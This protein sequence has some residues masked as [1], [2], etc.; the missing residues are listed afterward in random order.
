MW[1]GISN[2]YQ[3]IISFSAL[4]WL[5]SIRLIIHGMKIKKNGYFK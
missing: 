4:S 5:F 2:K 1:Y 3:I